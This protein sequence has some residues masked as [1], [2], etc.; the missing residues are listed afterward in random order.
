MN[1]S[2]KLS[3][4]NLVPLFEGETPKQGIDRSVALAQRLEE[5]DYVRYWVAEHHNF[6]GILSSATELL[7]GHTLAHTKR[8][9]VGAGGVMMPNHT[10][11]QIAERYGT[12]ETLY[13]NRVDLG[14]GRA[15]GTDQE[16]MR[17][18]YRSEFVQENAFEAAIRDL[19]RYFGPEEVQQRVIAQ[20]GIGTEVPLYILGSTAASAR[21]AARLGLPYAFAS[22]FA[23]HHLSEAAALYQRE[24]RPSEVLAEP[25]FIAGVVAV[26]AQTKETADYLYTST[27]K[28]YLDLV[29]GR[30]HKSTYRMPE[31]DFEKNLTS[32][33]KIILKLN[34][35]LSF[36]GDADGVRQQWNEFREKYP[37]DELM[38][39]SYI[40]DLDALT[41][42]YRILKEIV[43]P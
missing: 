37:V 28:M 35:G 5:L 8:I 22:H 31:E 27:Q 43:A 3:A 34:S 29:K 17:L 2:V 4:L 14:L 30:S 10:P 26:A 20:P 42:S 21:I 12:L 19:K 24:F 1:K 18:L 9:R 32:S 16:T 40:P 38:A 13:P 39:V 23:L 11:L 7:I 6:R 25:Y 15:P 41:T 36:R 33:E